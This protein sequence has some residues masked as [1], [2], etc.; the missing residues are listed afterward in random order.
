[1][2]TELAICAIF[3]LMMAL[4]V[5]VKPP[6]EVRIVKE[7]VPVVVREKEIQIVKVPTPVTEKPVETPV[8]APAKPRHKKPRTYETNRPNY[9]RSQA[10]IAGNCGCHT[11]YRARPSFF[12]DEY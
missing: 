8:P 11:T 6:P 3:L 7:P 9:G 12:K 10:R 4:V 1:M 2:K 5:W